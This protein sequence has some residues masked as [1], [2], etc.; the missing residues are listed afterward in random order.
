ML[1]W[2]AERRQ[3]A[4]GHFGFLSFLSVVDGFRRLDRMPGTSTW[5]GAVGLRHHRYRA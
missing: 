5:L 1:S 3:F 2:S 4:S